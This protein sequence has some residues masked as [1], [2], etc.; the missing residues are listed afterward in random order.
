M[1]QPQIMDHGLNRQGAKY[2]INV[3]SLLSIVSQNSFCLPLLFNGWVLSS[4]FVTPC[5]T[6]HQAPLSMGFPRQ[7][8]WRGLLF[9]SPGDLSNPG[10]ELLS[11]ALAG[12]FLTAWAITVVE[13]TN[14]ICTSL[15]VTTV[16]ISWKSQSKKG[17]FKKVNLSQRLLHRERVTRVYLDPI[18]TPA[19]YSPALFPMP[20]L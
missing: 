9:P 1:Q 3:K 6:V 19:L 20:R 15:Q 8:C 13:H 4:S 18:H 12:R 14:H 7:E 11:P 10:I 16:E 5:T 17:D 2:S